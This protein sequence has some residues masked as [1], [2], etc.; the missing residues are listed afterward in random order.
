MAN[1][2]FDRTNFGL[3]ERPVSADFNRNMSQSD[4]SLREA[5]KFMCSA[6]S[7]SSP[8][9]VPYTGF[10]GDG[11]RIVPTSPI[12]LSVQLTGGLGFFYDPVSLPVDLGATDL[13]GVD[14][15]SAYKPMMLTALQ[16][17]AVPAAPS[18]GNSRIDIIEARYD[19]RL[20]D[21][22]TRRQLDP[23]PKAFL[24]HVF[25][26]T[27]SFVLDGQIGTVNNPSQSTAPI[28]YKVGTTAATGSQVEPTVSTGYVKIAAISVGP[29]VTTID[30]N[31]LAD[32]RPILYPGGVIPFGGAWRLQWNGGSPIVTCYG[33]NAPPGIHVNLAPSH[34][35]KGQGTINVV[36]GNITGGSLVITAMNPAAAAG[37]SHFVMCVQ[38]TPFATGIVFTVG[39]NQ[40]ALLAGTPSINADVSSFLLQG[41]F[42]ALDMSPAGTN[43]ITNAIVEDIIVQ[44]TG[45]VRYA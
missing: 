37:A 34:T 12:G 9:G 6:R 38:N 41:Q 45:T 32:R 16:S 13:E 42:A 5:L 28:G 11:F 4:R 30:S 8:A 35:D 22:Q 26:K 7:L 40:A 14:D 27:L 3:R 21:S 2:A 10:F 19:R 20:E 31:V 24:D 15:R 39:A 44:A 33:S 17:F 36:G 29:N 1:N 43:T 25:S 18:T 23:T